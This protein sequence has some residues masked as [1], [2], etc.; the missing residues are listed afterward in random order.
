MYD[1]MSGQ[2]GDIEKYIGSLKDTGFY[3]DVN[4]NQF[5]K[6]H[7]DGIVYVKNDYWVGMSIEDNY[8]LV[9]ILYI[10]EFN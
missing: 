10:P 1:I 3:Y 2:S 9:M 4:A 6:D 8:L 7:F 5:F